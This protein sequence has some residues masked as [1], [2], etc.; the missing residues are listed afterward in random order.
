MSTYGILAPAGKRRPSGSELI[1]TR[2]TVSSPSAQRGNLGAQ[3]GSQ[4]FNYGDELYG[5]TLN[6][7]TLVYMVVFDETGAF[8]QQS[9]PVKIGDFGFSNTQLANI[10]FGFTWGTSGTLQK[11]EDGL[12]IDNEINRAILGGWTPV[13]GWSVPEPTSMALLALGAA[14]LGLRRRFRK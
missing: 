7:N 9:S 14:A 11:G 13:A 8:F 4:P 3:V 5:V 1:D 6:E 12:V 10:N 2:Y